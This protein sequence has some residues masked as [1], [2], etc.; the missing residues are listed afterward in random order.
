MHDDKSIDFLREKYKSIAPQRQDRDKQRKSY[1]IALFLIFFT[2]I[3]GLFTSYSLY[4]EPSNSSEVTLFDPIRRLLEADDRSLS[5]ESDDRINILL[6]G[7]GGAGH[8]GAELADTIILGSLQPSTN[9]ISML[10]IPRD[11]SVPTDKYGWVKINSLNAYAEQEKP[12]S[13]P[14]YTASIL[15]DLFG[16][17]IDY[18]AKVDFN[19][20]EKL[21]DSI[22]GINIYVERTFTDFSYPTENYL[23]EEITFE[24]GWQMMDGATALK[25]ARSR[26]GNNGE[27]TDF[28]R[29]ARQQKVI[30]ASKDKVFSA[31][32]LLNPAKLN[33]LA[34]L[35]N[36][37]VNT[38]MSVLNM[39]SLAKYA[40]EISSDNIQNFVLDNSPD[41]PLYDAYINDAYVLLPKK[42]DW[43]DIKFLV[44][45]MFSEEEIS[46]TAEK[47]LIAPA[48][49]VNISIQNGTLIPGL[50]GEIASILESSGF[51]VED[52]NNADNQNYLKTQI[53]DYTDGKKSLELTTLKEYFDADIVQSLEG[54]KNDPEQL[55]NT[56]LEDLPKTTKEVD[57]LV[58][59]GENARSILKR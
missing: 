8:E 36:R 56:I 18:Y 45:N 10:S 6:L 38:N 57:F 1:R 25:F 42:N 7:V 48:T 59:L 49:S 23:T 26:K 44:A 32:T 31:S 5:G 54:F 27:G 16:V 47:N 40:P 33:Q 2:L 13:G 17:K 19:G 28:A 14:E 29:A 24:Q 9:K 21:I 11:L 53:I 55:P 43:S 34:Q 15:S 58:I 4:A 39:V 20:F 3:G 35:F 22:G 41:S 37:Y 12:G 46:F 51:N 30:T 50:A 52:V